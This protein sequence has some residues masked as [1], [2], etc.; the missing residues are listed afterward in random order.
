MTVQFD[1]RM[2]AY[3]IFVIALWH[4]LR[5]F[6]LSGM[7]LVYAVLAQASIGILALLLHVPIGVALVHQAGAMIVLIASTWNLHKKTVL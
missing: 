7:L 1:H 5:T 3:A 6:S 4:A 2:L